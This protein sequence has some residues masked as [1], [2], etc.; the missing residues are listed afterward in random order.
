MGEELYAIVHSGSPSY[1]AENVCD[2]F[3]ELAKIAAAMIPGVARR[4]IAEDR[5]VF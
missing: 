5:R 2:K 4:I 1:E 3:V